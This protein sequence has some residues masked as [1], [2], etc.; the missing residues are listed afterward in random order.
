MPFAPRVKV[1][2]GRNNVGHYPAPVRPHFTSEPETFCQPGA[3][4]AERSAASPGGTYFLGEDKAEEATVEK[5]RW[6]R[7]RLCKV[8]LSRFFFFF[9]AARFMN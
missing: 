2:T 7:E 6:L 5:A 9:F 4:T 3:Q 1:K 8:V